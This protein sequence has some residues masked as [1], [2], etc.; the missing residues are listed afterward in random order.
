M[1]S[2]VPRTRRMLR[3]PAET[4]VVQTF[5][6]VTVTSVTAPDL[7]VLSPSVSDSSLT[8]GQTFTLRATVR[9]QG[10][11]TSAAT[12]L[13]YYRSSDATISTRDTQIG[14]DP[15]RA[16]PR[17]ASSPESI[18]LRAPSSAGTYYYGACVVSV[19]RESNTGNN[20]STSVRVT[21]STIGIRYGAIA[22]GWQG[23]FCEDG[24][25]WGWAVNYPDRNSAISAAESEC[26]DA[27]LSR[28]H[29]AVA[30]TSCG[31]LAFG[32][33]SLACGLRGGSGASRSAAERD[34]L[35]ECRRDFPSC[36]ISVDSNGRDASYC[37]ATANS[38]SS[39]ETESGGSMTD[40]P[41]DSGISGPRSQARPVPNSR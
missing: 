33:S 28:C 4:R 35:A 8:T 40:S 25:G 24:Y 13:R 2:G 23:E 22:P 36:V 18:G 7:V 21:V 3:M 6:Q 14:T 10:T 27:G 26:R 1:A 32:E 41:L 20:C 38:T 9:N 17:S 29:L 15:V 30:F 16:L 5:L 19:F 11:A 34:A 12:T 39:A 31:A 37:N